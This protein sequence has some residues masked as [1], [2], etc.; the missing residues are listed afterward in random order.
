M[1]KN[2]EIKMIKIK[3][4]NNEMEIKSFP[5]K[6]FGLMLSFT[7]VGLYAF[8]F[9]ENDFK[10]VDALIFFGVCFVGMA[11]H[12]YK[13]IEINKKKGTIEFQTK[14]I[15]KTTNNTIKI[16][17]IMSIDMSYGRGQYA[18][19]GCIIITTK[20]DDKFIIMDS[21][22]GKAKRIEKTKFKI[23]EFLNYKIN[24]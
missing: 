14:S 18:S 16:N 3:E 12:K 13:K 6:I 8:L 23:E 24:A 4:D 5:I 22:I 19:G 20:Q 10:L 9:K 17:D 7:L 11:I 2:K 1:N 21:D 15:M